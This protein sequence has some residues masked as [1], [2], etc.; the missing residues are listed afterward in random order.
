MSKTNEQLRN[1]YKKA[2]VNRRERIVAK[3][4]LKTESRYLKSL[5]SESVSVAPLPSSG[6]DML[7]QVIAFDT[8]S[9]M[10]S[11]ISAVKT[12]VKD[13]IPRLFAENPSL[14]LKIVAFG[15]YC[16]MPSADNFGRAYQDSGLS[17][18][19]NQLIDFVLKAQSTGGGDLDEFYEVVLKKVV[20]ETPWREGSKRALLLIGDCGPHAVGY[21]NP[22]QVRNA[23]IDWKEEAAKAVGLGIQIDTLNCGNSAVET[24]YKPLSNMTDGI[25]LPFSTQSKTQEAIYAVTSVRGSSMS[26]AAFSARGASADILED[27]ELGATYS[28]LSKKLID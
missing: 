3:S 17:D 25:N 14:R 21:S 22:P 19:P 13:L 24:F 18:N 20:E 15:D 28:A 5:Q 12:H 9:S 8:T 4:G 7:D 27:A 10:D 16:D 6:T 2:N 1:A 26:K 11:Y 23:Q